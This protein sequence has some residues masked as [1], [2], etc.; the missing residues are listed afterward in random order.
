MSAPSEPDDIA[1][2]RDPAEFAR[3]RAGG[4]GVGGAVALGLVCV[5]LGFAGS[6][7]A[8][9]VMGSGAAAPVPASP[10]PA[11]P[12]PLPA[13]TPPLAGAPGDA[14]PASAAIEAAEVDVLSTR[15]AALEASQER[16]L[17][18]A[19]AALAAAT[20][21]DA[22]ET[23]RPFPAELAA[24]ERALPLSAEARALRPLAETGAPSRLALAREFEPAA[25]RASAAAR[26]PGPNAGVLDR[27]LHALSRVVTLRRVGVEGN[28]VDAILARAEQRV[29]E[30]DLEGALTA[31]DALPPGAREAMAGWRA[32]AQ[33][34]VALDRYL[35]AIRAQALAEL[36]GARQ[37]LTR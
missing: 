4:I 35:A 30:G 34:R 29:M 23:S 3:R 24:L 37:S 36:T 10:Q 6:Q 9:R 32:R 26:E 7:F 8:Q 22:A 1:P 11:Q 17:G 31:L 12:D 25:G 16:A 27:I 5:I 19:G 33:Q 2:P 15:L 13:F 14:T 28:G 21:A 18:A 20:L